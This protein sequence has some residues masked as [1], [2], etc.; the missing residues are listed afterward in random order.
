MT[1]WA[2]QSRAE[3]W[4]RCSITDGQYVW[5]SPFKFLL[6][7]PTENEKNRLRKERDGKL[8]TEPFI[9]E[10]MNFSLTKLKGCRN[11]GASWT[12]KEHFLLNNHSSSSSFWHHFSSEEMD[13]GHCRHMY[14]GRTAMWPS[15]NRK[16]GS[17]GDFTWQE[18]DGLTYHRIRALSS[19]SGE[20]R[21]T[22]KLYRARRWCFCKV[23]KPDMSSVP[24]T[25]AR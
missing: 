4:G 18:E 8:N 6:S 5:Q 15:L 22:N 3:G 19:F 10:T 13:L 1:P 21:S 20:P 17:C 25:A 2:Q 11:R 7:C 14:S 16:K 23:Q 12:P 9:D 24:T